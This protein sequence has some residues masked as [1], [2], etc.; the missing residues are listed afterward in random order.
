[1]LF[2]SLGDRIV[3]ARF[4][5]CYAGS[6]AVG[7]EALSRGAAWCVFIENDHAA[8]RALK[9]N[10]RELGYERRAQVWNANVRTSLE[11]LQDD[12]QHFDI[13]FADP[14]FR[15]PTETREFCHRIDTAARLLN[16]VSHGTAPSP[17]DFARAKNAHSGEGLLILQHHRKA[18]PEAMEHFELRREKRAGE[19]LLSF[20]ALR[21]PN[22]GPALEDTSLP[23]DESSPSFL[24]SQQSLAEESSE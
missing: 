14:P 7:L 19:S 9:T 23:A 24:K 4:L 17:E 6:G 10:L 15:H 22:G 13:V 20:F 2:N 8:L 16:N 18:S 1:M 5:D 21:T 12:G 3:G 11:K